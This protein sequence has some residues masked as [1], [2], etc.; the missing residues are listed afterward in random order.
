MGARNAPDGARGE[1]GDTAGGVLQRAPSAARRG[2][3]GGRGRRWALGSVPLGRD[4]GRMVDR[5][6]PS[7]FSSG[8]SSA[9]NAMAAS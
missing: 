9:D 2:H 8:I 5:S 6:V 1:S 4:A 7:C 3:D